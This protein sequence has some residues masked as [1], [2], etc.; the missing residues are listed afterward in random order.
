VPSFGFDPSAVKVSDEETNEE[1]EITEVTEVSSSSPSSVSVTVSTDS[2]TSSV[3]EAYYYADILRDTEVR[4][5]DRCFDAEVRA[6][7]R[8]MYQYY[9]T[10]DTAYQYDWR[11]QHVRNMLRFMYVTYNTVAVYSL[12]LLR[13]GDIIYYLE[14]FPIGLHQRVEGKN[15]AYVGGRD[16]NAAVKL[17]GRFA[18]VLDVFG[19]HVKVAELATFNNK[20][21]AVAKSQKYWHE[22]AGIRSSDDVNYQHPSQAINK[23]LEVGFSCCEIPKTTS[24]HLITSRISLSNQI[25][26]AGNITS[27]SLGRLRT[28]IRKLESRGSR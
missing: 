14:A 13:A 9:S 20:G 28:S 12:N 23:P 4:L 11:I 21:L 8:S 2:S 18:I 19:Q 1:G 3:P 15:A 27:D 24:V 7:K 16:C 5:S 6:D 25:M 22:Y 17:K 26:I 10:E